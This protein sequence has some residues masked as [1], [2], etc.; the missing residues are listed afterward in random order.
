[1]I[2][3]SHPNVEQVIAIGEQAP[4]FILPDQTGAPRRLNDAVAAG[5]LLLVFYR[6]DW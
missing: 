6:G 3:E 4:T 2:S 1:M 5:A